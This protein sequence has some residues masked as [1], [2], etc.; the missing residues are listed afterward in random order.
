MQ[1]T[2][3]SGEPLAKVAAVV[4]ALYGVE[5]VVADGSAPAPAPSRRRGRS[6]ATP[7]VA[8]RSAGRARRSGGTKTDPKVIRQW[9]VEQGYTVSTRGQLPKA[10]LTAYAESNS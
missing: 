1:I 2:I 3:D 7:S 5:L 8:K 6:A 4:G 10:V 9:A